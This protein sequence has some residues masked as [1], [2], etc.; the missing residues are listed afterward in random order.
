MEP[1]KDSEKEKEY[2]EEITD[3]NEKKILEDFKRCIATITDK[4]DREVLDIFVL[5]DN[6]LLIHFL[7]A[8][9]LDVKKAT[10][11]LLEYFH[12]KAKVNLDNL[13]S[14]YTWKNKNKMLLLLPHGFHKIT[15][16]GYPVYFQIMGKL[17]SDEFFKLITPEE[18]VTYS[19]KIYE[20]MY[21]DYFKLC[22]KIKDRYVY[23]VFNIID[24]K[25]VKVTSLLSKNLLKYLNESTNI[26]QNYYP[27][28]IANI[29]A[30]NTGFAFRAF[31]AA[32]KF[33]LDA[34]TKES[35]KVFDENYQ[36][37]LLE[38][39]DKECLPTFYGGTCE[40]PGGC[41][42]SNAGPWKKEDEKEEEL[43]EDII[44]GRKEVTEYM[45]KRNI[46][47]DN[48]DNSE[49]INNQGKERVNP[50]NL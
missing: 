13:Y 19:T 18:L 34:K 20:T 26:M 6:D 23:G 46:N 25:D 24:F 35:I 39:I 49:K 28:S 9:K 11:M 21:R 17:D 12:W 33:F 29:Y 37:G 40:C 48:N 22:S 3:P 7:R 45:F 32:V 14:N 30:I 38:R 43:P 15:K 47:N 8:N 31:Y 36:E 2:H 5:S 27:E 42:F 4:K 41:L 1:K 50:D 16:E 44:K 10:N